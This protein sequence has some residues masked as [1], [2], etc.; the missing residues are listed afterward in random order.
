MADQLV[1][2]TALATVSSTAALEAI[3][4]GLPV[5]VLSDFGVS[6]GMLNK[7][8]EGSGLFGTLK[9][10][11]AGRFF[12]PEP[13]WLRENYFHRQDAQLADLLALYAARARAGKLASGAVELS[14]AR[15]RRLRQ[16]LR[17]LLPAPALRLVLQLRR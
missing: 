7:V 4:A 12:H 3:D 14:A 16:R 15:R 8:F 17:T 10:L 5:L 13:G 1:P 9:D 2:G 11:T 6:D